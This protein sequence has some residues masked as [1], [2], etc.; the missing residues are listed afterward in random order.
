[1]RYLS[2]FNE[3]TLKAK[4]DA[5]NGVCL[6]CDLRPNHNGLRE[7]EHFVVVIPKAKIPPHGVFFHL[8]T[9]TAMIMYEPAATEYH[10][11]VVI[12]APESQ[13]DKELYL[14]PLCGGTAPFEAYPTVRHAMQMDGSLMR[15]PGAKPRNW[16]EIQVYCPACSFHDQK[17]AF[18]SSGWR[19]LTGLIKSQSGVP[20]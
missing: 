20:I 14:C 6:L 11:T 18:D 13:A 5:P 7:S 1:M 12:K 17:H 16:Q 10:G 15:S 19:D 4:L 8:L 3:N 9:D 2:F